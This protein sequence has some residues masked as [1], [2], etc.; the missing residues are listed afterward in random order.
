MDFDELTL[1]GLC[2]SERGNTW[3]TNEEGN[4]LILVGLNIN[5]DDSELSQLI[6]ISIIPEN[7]PGFNMDTINTYMADLKHDIQ[8]YNEGWFVRK[9][10]LPF[11]APV[12]EN[13]Y[14]IGLEEEEEVA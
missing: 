2:E 12:T 3:L 10:N 7:Y 9:W 11:K 4:H 13:G 14:I 6:Q 5:E 1:E 8:D